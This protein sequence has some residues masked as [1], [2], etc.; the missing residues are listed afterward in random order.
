[1]DEEL[2][3]TFSDIYQ[4]KKVLLTGH[5]G[6]KGS[7]LAFWL[8]RLGADV[9]GYSLPAP[10][11]PSHWSL[12]NL[13][14]RS[15]IADIR[16]VQRLENVFCGFQ[17]EVV[18]HLAAQPL[19]R[20]SYRDPIET[21]STNVMGTLNVLE[22]CRKT[23]S[24]R[25]VVNV[26]SDKCYE[27]REWKRGYCED[28]P[29]GGHDP[30]SSS[31]GCSELLT[32][33][34]RKSFFNNAMFGKTHHVLLASCR[35]GN[36]VGGGDWAED[37]LI[38]DIMRATADGKPVEIRNPSATRPWQHV[39]EALSGYLLVGQR[40]LENKPQYAEGWNFGPAE[41]SDFPVSKVVENTKRYW[42]RID[43]R[44]V[45]TAGAPQE[46]ALLKLNCTKA[47]E[48]LGWTSA[49]DNATT[50]KRTIDWYREYYENG[51][52]RTDSD[53]IAYVDGSRCGNEK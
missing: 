46:A 16:D 48:Q 52:V 51:T 6:F 32:A 13:D 45:Q 40:L 50:F 8:Q 5:T 30:Y 38:P 44:L 3:M 22:M 31:K 15:E 2:D 20:A 53:L 25:A 37:R 19:V 43:Y 41:E 17:P 49:W 27:N 10:T 26:T 24:V 9:C 42:D 33:S 47:R 14:I 12:L 39:L 28:D 36:V 29:M 18:F 23:E 11:E 4:G 35:A 34:Y 7:W 21:Y 1:M